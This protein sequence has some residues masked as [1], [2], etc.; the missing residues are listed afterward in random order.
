MSIEKA[1]L[2]CEEGIAVRVRKVD[3]SD[4]ERS[5]NWADSGKVLKMQPNAR[6]V[7]SPSGGADELISPRLPR[8]YH[9]A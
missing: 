9:G 3:G 1:S 6:S 4:L 8:Q 2:W 7:V 5:R